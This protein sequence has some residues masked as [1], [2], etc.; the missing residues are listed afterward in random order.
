MEFE[1]SGRTCD[2]LDYEILKDKCIYLNQIWSNN[3]NN[4]LHQ[5]ALLRFI[6][7][8]HVTLTFKIVQIGTF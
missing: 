1:L 5:T 3:N 6:K 7:K 8:Q 2:I 4:N